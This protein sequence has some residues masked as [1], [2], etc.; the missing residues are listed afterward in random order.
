MK[1]ASGYIV[2]LYNATTAFINPAIPD[3]IFKCPK[4][5]FIDV[6]AQYRFLSV[7]ATSASESALASIES[8][9]GVAEA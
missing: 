7:N 3:A 5:L 1:F 6:T 2:L 4:L 8:P 9:I